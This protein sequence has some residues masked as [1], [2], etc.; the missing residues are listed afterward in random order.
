MTQRVPTSA[1]LELRT[2]G[3]GG[4]VN[5]KIGAP[6]VHEGGVGAGCEGRFHER[7]SWLTSS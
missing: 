2:A 1:D 3:V 5:G 7:P 4:R 6:T